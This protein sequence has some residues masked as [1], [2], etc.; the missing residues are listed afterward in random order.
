VE[1]SQTETVAD[2]NIV[3]NDWEDNNNNNQPN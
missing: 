3:K 1:E 2:E